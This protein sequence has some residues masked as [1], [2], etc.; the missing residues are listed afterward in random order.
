MTALTIVCSKEDAF[1]HMLTGY[2]KRRIGQ[3]QTNAAI[4]T[5]RLASEPDSE[6]E[7]RAIVDA[8][9]AA[10]RIAEEMLH[11][12]QAPCRRGCCSV[13]SALPSEKEEDT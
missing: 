12:V 6:E 8:L 11:D 3:I 2:G 1:K 5:T 13:A 4:V 9:R 7:W 10:T